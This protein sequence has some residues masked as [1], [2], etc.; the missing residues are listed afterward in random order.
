MTYA[1]YEEHVIDQKTF[2]VSVA[3]DVQESDYQFQARKDF[4]LRMPDVKFEVRVC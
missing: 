4:R 2:E 3:A 1:E